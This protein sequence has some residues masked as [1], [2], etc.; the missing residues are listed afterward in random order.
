MLFIS[1]TVSKSYPAGKWNIFNFGVNKSSVL[2]RKYR[3]RGSL[4]N[5]FAKGILMFYGNIFKHIFSLRKANHVK[6]HQIK[7]K[8]LQ[9][10]CICYLVV[11]HLLLELQLIKHAGWV[12]PCVLFVLLQNGSMILIRSLLFH[13][14]SLNNWKY[15][16]CNNEHPLTVLHTPGAMLSTLHS[17]S[18][19]TS[20]QPNEVEYICFP[21]QTRK[22]SLRELGTSKFRKKLSN[23]P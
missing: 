6:M 20:Q 4:D 7:A 1:V 8:F 11:E 10:H 9:K 15:H 23:A 3:K 5:W 17:P 14:S 22:Q 18:H 19:L 21:L 13:C 12:P 16:C 2:G